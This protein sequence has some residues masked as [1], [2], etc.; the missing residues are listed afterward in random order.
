MSL[1]KLA[2]CAGLGIGQFSQGFE[3]QLDW[4]ELAAAL[5]LDP[6][7]LASFSRSSGSAVPKHGKGLVGRCESLVMVINFFSFCLIDL[8]EVSRQVLAVLD[9]CKSCQ[10]AGQAWLSSP[11]TGYEGLRLL[12]ELLACGLAED[13][14]PA[15][16]WSGWWLSQV[17]CL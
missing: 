13:D 3:H 5:V 17:C 7:A 9:C 4:G 12:V 10:R 6:D 1:G 16:C 15:L 14:P 8:Y 11:F 2:C